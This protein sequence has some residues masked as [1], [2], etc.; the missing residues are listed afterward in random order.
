MKVMALG[1]GRSVEESFSQLS[2]LHGTGGRLSVLALNSRRQVQE[3]AVAQARWSR[4]GGI[5]KFLE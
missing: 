3:D 5:S 1:E 2:R 4:D